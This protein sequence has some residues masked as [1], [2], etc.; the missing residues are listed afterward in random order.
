M[1]APRGPKAG[2]GQGQAAQERTR[3]TACGG[4]GGFAE[5]L[6]CPFCLTTRP[7]PHPHKVLTVN[8]ISDGW[9]VDWDQSSGRLSHVHV[10]VHA[11]TEK[12]T[13]THMRTPT[14]Y[15]VDNIEVY[16]CTAI[17]HACIVAH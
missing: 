14:Q 12:Y 16:C 13:R 4:N 9:A 17:V 15:T 10:H 11:H 3:P 6:N 2:V 1:T 5:L 7:L 8:Q